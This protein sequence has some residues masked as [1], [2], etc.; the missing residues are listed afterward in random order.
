MNDA[1][2]HEEWHHLILAPGVEFVPRK[3]AGDLAPALGRIALDEAQRLRAGAGWILRDE[4]AEPVDRA[5]EVLTSLGFPFDRF[6]TEE[7][8]EPAEFTRVIEAHLDGGH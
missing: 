6:W 1:G 4:S 7:P 3:L 5:A 8:I 2:V